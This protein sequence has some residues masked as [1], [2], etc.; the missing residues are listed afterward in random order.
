M[1][2]AADPPVRWFANWSLFTKLHSGLDTGDKGGRHISVTSLVAFELPA[3]NMSDFCQ[4]SYAPLCLRLGFSD[5]A[6]Q[7]VTHRS[8]VC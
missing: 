3:L 1:H 6:A 2:I 4:A 7:H 5:P 8:L